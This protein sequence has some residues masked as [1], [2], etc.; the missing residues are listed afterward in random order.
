MASCED[1]GYPYGQHDPNQQGIDGS[2]YPFGECTDFCWRYYRDQ[3][4]PVAATMGDATD[5]QAGAG[6]QHYAVYDRLPAANVIA[7]W[8]ASAY[9]PFGHVAAV[10]DVGQDG[11]FTV[12]EMNFCYSVDSMPGRVD[13]RTV[14]AAD[15]Q[16]KAFI[17]PTGAGL[18]AG[19]AQ[20]FDLQ[21]NLQQ[22]LDAPLK[23]IATAIDHAGLEAQAAI[24]TLRQRIVSGGQIGLGA[25]IALA[26]GGVIVLAALGHSPAGV[27][28]AGAR[29]V[30]RS[31]RRSSRQAVPAIREQFPQSTPQV[32]DVPPGQPVRIPAARATRMLAV[33]RRPPVG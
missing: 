33:A 7:C 17:L 26:G 28:S 10:V 25:T 8:D 31:A 2:P 1:L 13:R 30:S 15:P 19:S 12:H 18:G 6:V 14:A 9:P 32:P 29:R 23:G 4:V 27:A 20:L 24:M 5:W 11:A 22:T 16:P 21:Q 3:S